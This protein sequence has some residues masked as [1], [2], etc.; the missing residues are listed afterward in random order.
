MRR[1]RRPRLDHAGTLGAWLRRVSAAGLGAAT[2]A[3]A[4]GCCAPLFEE[5]NAGFATS[6][7]IPAREDIATSARHD[8]P[9]PISLC[10][11]VC[12]TDV[13]FPV[14]VVGPS[15]VTSQA[16][17]CNDFNPGTCRDSNFFSLPSGRRSAELD[18]ASIEDV[19]AAVA[20]A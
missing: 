6:Q 18:A 12:N 17:A 15:G 3:A 7:I 13:C 2:A 5:W 14:E 20:L 4:T 8:R 11:S 16:I 19:L 9:L 1:R 10:R